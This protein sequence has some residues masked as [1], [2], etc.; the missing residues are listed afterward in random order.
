MHAKT[1]STVKYILK[2]EL[3]VSDYR[4]KNGAKEIF[5]ININIYVS[6]K[7]TI[8]SRNRTVGTGSSRVRSCGICGGQSVTGEGFLRVLL[9]PLPIIP[10]TAPHS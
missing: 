6:L 5:Y 10:P 9:F 8:S 2:N 1:E 4:K 3:L 7:I